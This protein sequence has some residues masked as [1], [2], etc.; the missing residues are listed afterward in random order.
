MKLDFFCRVHTANPVEPAQD[1]KRNKIDPPR[2]PPSVVILDTE[3]IENLALDFE[4][5][6]YEYCELI[7]RTYVSREEGIFFR[8]D[9]QLKLART[10]R[11]YAERPPA[12]LEELAQTRIRVRTRTDFVKNVLWP[13]L[14]AG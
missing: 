12:H 1:E 8:G 3:T 10:I 11:E 4:F 5:G 9:L 14:R 7:D 2:L 13:T 6:C